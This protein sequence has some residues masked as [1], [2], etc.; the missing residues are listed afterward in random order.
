M[1][2]YQKTKIIKANQ[3]KSVAFPLP[4]GWK[5]VRKIGKKMKR[6]NTQ[7]GKFDIDA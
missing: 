6:W 2:W 1:R 3:V 5:E 4:E 7:T